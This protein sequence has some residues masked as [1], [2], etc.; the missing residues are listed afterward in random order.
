ML[1]TL[2]P[3]ILRF[4]EA[5]E[6]IIW[7]RSYASV[8]CE[9]EIT[10]FTEHGTFEIIH[11][12]KT[13]RSP[14][15][16][17]H[18][19]PAIPFMVH[20]GRRSGIPKRGEVYVIV[21]LQL[22]GH[23]VG[24]LIKGYLSSTRG[25]DWPPTHFE[26]PLSGRGALKVVVGTDPAPGSELSETVPTNAVWRLLALRV[27]FTTDPTVVNRGV[28]LEFDDGST[29]IFTTPDVVAQAA[30]ETRTYFFATLGESRIG[31]VGKGVIQITI[32]DLLLSEGYRVRTSTVN[33]Q[34][35]DDFLTPTLFVEEWLRD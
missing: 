1:R 25:L 29:V 2:P 16:T 31:T 11:T 5:K 8:A 15:S 4:L 10:G 33:L 21:G 9:L 13:D 22:A 32:P 20:V 14:V 26:D 18:R 3:E 7:V 6:P 12:C 19:L 30:G 34:A 23:I 17:T 27:T 24:D 35:G 28:R